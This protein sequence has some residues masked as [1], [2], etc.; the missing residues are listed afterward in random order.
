MRKVPKLHR[1]ESCRPALQNIKTF[2]LPYL[3]GYMSFFNSKC[4]TIRWNVA[5]SYETRDR[6]SYRNGQ[7]ITIVQERLHRQVILSKGCQKSKNS[8]PMPKAFKTR[9]KH[10]LSA[11]EFVAYDWEN[12]HTLT[13]GLQWN[14]ASGNT[15]TAC[16]KETLVFDVRIYGYL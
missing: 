9:F 1:R 13:I 4:G 6:V 8:T 15:N 7:Y 2:T 16:L 12:V 14:Y 11:Q 5:H 10:I 3:F